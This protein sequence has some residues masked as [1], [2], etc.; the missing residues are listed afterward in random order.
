VPHRHRS[1]PRLTPALA[2]LAACLLSALA[3]GPVFASNEGDEDEK[4]ESPLSSLKV[5]EILRF[6]DIQLGDDWTDFCVE[7]V[8]GTSEPA[9]RTEANKIDYYARHAT[10]SLAVRI[11]AG[12]LLGGH[13]RAGLLRASLHDRFHSSSDVIVGAPDGEIRESVRC[14]LGAAFGLGAEIRMP[15]RDKARLGLSYEIGYG[16]AKVE[17][18]RFFLTPIEGEYRYFS[19]EFLLFADLPIRLEKPFRGILRPRLSLGALVVRG[20]ADFTSPGKD[21]DWDLHWREDQSFLLRFTLKLETEEGLFAS[22]S[23]DVIARLG[24]RLG[25]GVRF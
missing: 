12:T 7:K 16:V 18:E 22:L 6:V 17:N 1:S 9:S 13:F 11:E 4:K 15:V 5:G 25:V 8:R 23:G 21:Y 10:T 19:H 3:A 14:E 2:C 24:V 20:A